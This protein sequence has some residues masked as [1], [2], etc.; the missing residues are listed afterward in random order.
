MLTA[1]ALLATAFVQFRQDMNE[2]LRALARVTA[3]NTEASL[4]FDDDQVAMETLRAFKAV[5]SIEAAGVY[6]GGG[7]IFAKYVR[8]D[9]GGLRR[10]A[11]S[12]ASLAGVGST[13]ISPSRS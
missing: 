11:S 1:G 2:N 13:S 6:D 3:A 8:A 12:P 9:I 10:L 7:A 5:E 4:L